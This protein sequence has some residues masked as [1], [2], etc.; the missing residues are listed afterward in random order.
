MNRSK[1]WML[2]AAVTALASTAAAWAQTVSVRPGRYETTVEMQMP[3]TPAPMKMKNFD[4]LS[5]EE[6]GDLVKAMNQE[7][8]KQGQT[9][10]LA[11]MKMSPGKVTYDATCDLEAGSATATSEMVYSAETF[12]L[13][14]T[15]KMP[16]GATM[17]MKSNGKW[18]GATCQKDDR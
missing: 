4:C 15:M 5:A 10:K 7:L 18:V 1:I 9:C 2:A 14:V 13:A 16:N 12:S 17:T 11:N 8:A 6:A 3:G